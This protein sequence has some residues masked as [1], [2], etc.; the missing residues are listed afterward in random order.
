MRRLRLLTAVVVL[1][2][3]ACG[4]SDGDDNAGSSAD[5]D[6]TEASGTVAPDSPAATDATATGPDLV[7]ENLEIEEGFIA[8][9]PVG[10]VL[11]DF[12]DVP[13]KFEAPEDSGF[14]TNEE[15]TYWVSQQ[16]AGTCQARSSAEWADTVEQNLFSPNRRPDFDVVVRDEVAEG[17][18][19]LETVNAGERVWTNL[20]IARWVDGQDKI[21]TCH[22]TLHENNIDLMSEFEE[23]CMAITSTVLESD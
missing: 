16:C 13:G 17:F 18:A 14:E 12:L 1:A 15:P 19:L 8:A 20:R 2:M 23:A 11:D 9:I 22:L 6:S 10:W 7:F 21:I 5:L 4:G 3:S